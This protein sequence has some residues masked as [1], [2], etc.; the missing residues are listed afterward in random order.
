MM[1]SR[2]FART[3]IAA[4]FAALPA[5]AAFADNADFAALAAHSD[6]SQ[7]SP[8]YGPLEGFEGV[9]GVEERGRYKINYDVLE[10][11]G[12]RPLT[13]YVNYLEGLPVHALSKDD[14]LAYWINLHNLMVVQ[15]INADPR[16]RGFEE[17]RGTG[18][19]PGPM[20]TEKRVTVKDVALS[21][22][23]IEDLIFEIFDNPDAIYGLYQGFEGGPSLKA[24]GFRGAT[25]NAELK[26]LARDSVNSRSWLRVRKRRIEISS[27]YD[28]YKEAAFGG[29][30]AAVKAHL[31]AYLDDADDVAKL[32]TVSET[33]I[34]SFDY[35]IDKYVVRQQVSGGFGGG[36]GLSGG[37]GGGFGS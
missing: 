27:L 16:K 35:D 4:L 10:R 23:D 21:I 15:A 37:G 3:A 14:Q 13:R 22:Q 36:G 34:K 24:R 1:K 11:S 28:W 30:D 5:S 33:R 12:T 26:E 29:D 20:W 18:A 19:Q 17:K 32:N 31:A 6:A 2:F 8:D 9:F 25:V 7:F